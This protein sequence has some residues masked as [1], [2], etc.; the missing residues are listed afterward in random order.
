METIGI[1]C[2][3][4]SVSVTMIIVKVEVINVNDDDDEKTTMIKKRA[5]IRF[6]LRG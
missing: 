4:L 1:D 5:T 2:E 3:L 6:G